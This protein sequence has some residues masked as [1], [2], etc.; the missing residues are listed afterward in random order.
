[1]NYLDPQQSPVAYLVLIAAIAFICFV[2]WS[3]NRPLRKF[4]VREHHVDRMGSSMLEME[5][6]FRPK[7]EHVITARQK[8]KAMQPTGDDDPSEEQQ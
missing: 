4:G 2:L 1:M 6:M 7:A 8:R 5:R 3:L